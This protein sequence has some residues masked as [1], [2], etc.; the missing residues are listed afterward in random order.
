MPRRQRGDILSTYV[1]KA[2]IFIES[3]NVWQNLTFDWRRLEWLGAVTMITS[4][5]R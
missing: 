5:P 2:E 4:Y 1:M 3:F